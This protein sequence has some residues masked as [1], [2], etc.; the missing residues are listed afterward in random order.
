MRCSWLF[1]RK[2]AYTIAVSEAGSDKSALHTT[3]T[4]GGSWGEAGSACTTDIRRKRSRYVICMI[5]SG[6]GSGS[7]RHTVLFK[8][9]HSSSSVVHSKNRTTLQMDILRAGS[10]LLR[11][12]S[13]PTSRR[14]G[15]LLHKEAILLATLRVSVL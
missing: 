11:S 8:D 14:G 13:Y 5:R 3:L 4:Q 6:I 12:P 2:A 10:S 1:F 9:V 15:A 7:G